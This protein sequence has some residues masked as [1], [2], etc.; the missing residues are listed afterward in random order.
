LLA[1]LSTPLLSL[2][3]SCSACR[4]AFRPEILRLL[5]DLEEFRIYQ[6]GREFRVRRELSK[7]DVELF[8]PTQKAELH[9]PA[10]IVWERAILVRPGVT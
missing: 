6:A 1:A 3:A 5:A 4:G 8:A 9:Q 2:S 7:D 10:A